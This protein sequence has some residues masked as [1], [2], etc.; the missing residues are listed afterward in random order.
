MADRLEFDD[1]DDPS[2]SQLFAVEELESD[3]WHDEELRSVFQHQL[4]ARLSDDLENVDVRDLAPGCD[5]FH[6]LFELR[7]PSLELLD[8]VKDFAKKSPL[9]KDVAGVLYLLAI[10]ASL[11][12]LDRR[13]T[14]HSDQALSA[15]LEWALQ[16]PWLEANQQD[17]LREARAKLKS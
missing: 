2:L 5:T 6:Q 3:S 11:V 13:S 1:V 17:L 14:S 7:S 16:I 12:R 15:R 4:A 8:A 9:P 10:S